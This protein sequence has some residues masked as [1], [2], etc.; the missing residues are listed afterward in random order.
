M[1]D[2]RLD[3]L[4]ALL[5]AA[6]HAHHAV[7]GG[8]RRAWARWYAEWMYGQLSEVLASAPSV[9]TVEEWLTRADARYTAERPDGSWPRMYATWFLEWDGEAGSG[10]PNS[11]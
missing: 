1:D 10:V 7:Y 3:E 9:D 11:N 5:V 2:P 8:A 6:A 4:K